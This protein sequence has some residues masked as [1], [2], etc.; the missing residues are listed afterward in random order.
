MNR[1]LARLTSPTNRTLVAVSSILW[2]W[3][4]RPPNG[5]FEGSN[6]FNRIRRLYR[7]WFYTHISSLSELY[8]NIPISLTV[9]GHPDQHHRHFLSVTAVSLGQFPTH[10]LVLTCS[11]LMATTSIAM[12]RVLFSIHSLAANIGS[13]SAWLLNNVELSRVKWKKGAHEGE[14]L[15]DYNTIESCDSLDLQRNN[16]R[17]MVK[18]THVG[19]IHEPT[20]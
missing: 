12:S 7:N 11:V 9:H 5:H 4:K 16:G 2:Y 13:S 15:V 3:V 17:P 10:S 19:V 14:I 6:A 18:T 8:R 1:F 20:W